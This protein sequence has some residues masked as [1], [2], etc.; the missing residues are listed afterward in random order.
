[1]EKTITVKI[2]N[3]IWVNDF[4]ENKTATFTYNGPDVVWIIVEDDNTVNSYSESMPTL[5]GNQT[6]VEIDLA[7][8]STDKQQAALL[9]VMKS[10]EH[11]YTYTPETN[12]DGSIYQKIVNPKL[13]DY[14]TLRYNPS[15]GFELK[16]IEKDKTI[17]TEAIAKER[18]EY[19]E[20]YSSAY[21]FSDSDEA[22]ISQYLTSINDYLSSVE[23][24]YPWKYVNINKNEVPKIPVSL[25]QLFNTLPQL[26]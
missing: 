5:Q 3:E 18:K 12:H 23:T 2:P 9:Q 13:S 21:E 14:Y 24:A 19:V 15:Q 17:P 16:V 25:V 8:A 4:S 10:S 20:K 6:S 22:M 11:V 1:M 26:P 7:T